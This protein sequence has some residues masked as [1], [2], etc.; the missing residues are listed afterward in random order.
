MN[1][2]VVGQIDHPHDHHT[3]IA[4]IARV[5]GGQWHP[6]NTIPISLRESSLKTCSCTVLCS[7]S[8]VPLLLTKELKVD[9]YIHHWRPFAEM[10]MHSCSSCSCCSRHCLSNCTIIVHPWTS[11]NI[12]VDSWFKSLH[13]KRPFK[14]HWG[15]VYESRVYIMAWEWPH[16]VCCTSI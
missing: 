1:Q 6:P 14:Y 15:W 9:L 16:D 11:L 3:Q 5:P 7:C 2:M 12:N 10:V 13:V 4:Q 8:P